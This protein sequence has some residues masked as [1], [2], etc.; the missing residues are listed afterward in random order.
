MTKIEAIRL[1]ALPLSRQPK[2]LTYF[3]AQRLSITNQHHRFSDS[4]RSLFSLL[5]KVTD[6]G[7][8]TWLKLSDSPPGSWKARIHNAGEGFM[9]KIPYEEW[10]LKTIDP[11]VIPSTINLLHQHSDSVDSSV[12]KSGSKPI[13]L[14]YPPS[15]C[16]GKE[17][18]NGL[19][20]S[21]A[22]RAPYHR[23]WMKLNF[24]LSP[25]TMP[26]VIVP[27]IPNLPFFYMMWRAWSHWR[28]YKASEYLHQMI[29][30]AHVLPTPC[31]FLETLYFH[32]N[33]ELVDPALRKRTNTCQNGVAGD[34]I[35]SQ[36]MVS[37]LQEHFQLPNESIAEICRGINQ[38]RQRVEATR[39]PPRNSKA[40]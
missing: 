36:D 2:A 4:N 26:F 31:P 40:Q 7:A 6:L 12:E 30:Q 13:E 15:L 16:S 23:K 10:A 9:D 35:L 34:V 3:Y 14:L 25:L 1:I 8:K 24:F 22:E 5:K 20:I 21:M 27:L 18:L 11:A 17:L 32:A 39:L 28:A 38:A 19:E 29:T 37:K 33:L